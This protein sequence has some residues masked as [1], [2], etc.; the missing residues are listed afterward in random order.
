MGIHQSRNRLT[1]Q[2]IQKIIT[3]LKSVDGTV[4]EYK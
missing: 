4:I 2:E 3:F 1:N